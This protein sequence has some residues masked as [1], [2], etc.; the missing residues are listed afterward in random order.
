VDTGSREENASKQ[1]MWNDSSSVAGDIGTGRRDRNLVI[2]CDKRKS[3][4]ARERSDQAIQ[5]L[6]ATSTGL[7]RWRSQ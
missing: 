3:V 4:C 5:Y 6:G 7:L 1:T 2:A